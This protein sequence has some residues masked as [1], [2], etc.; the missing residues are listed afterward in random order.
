MFHEEDFFKEIS[1]LQEAKL[2]ILL[3]LVSPSIKSLI[4][5]GVQGTGKSHLAS[6]VGSVTNEPVIH[7]P[8]NATSDR[9]FGSVD[10]SGSLIQGKKILEYGLL[11]KADG[12]FLIIDDIQ[13]MDHSLITAILSTAETGHV[14]IEREGL[15][16]EYTTNFKVLATFNPAE[17][18][19]TPHLLDRFSLCAICE[20][21]S[22]PDERKRLLKN[23]IERKKAG[24]TGSNQS[25]S[26]YQKNHILKARDHYQYVS[27]PDGLKD[28]ITGLGKELGIIGHRGE[29]AHSYAARALTSLHEHDQVT[30]DD[31]SATAQ[32]ALQHRRTDIAREQN[33]SREDERIQS[34]QGD[35]PD[36][37]PEERGTPQTGVT[38]QAWNEDHP[39]ADSQALAQD[40]VFDIA[41]Y[42]SARDILHD[43]RTMV[44]LSSGKSGRRGSN[45]KKSDNG[46][47]HRSKIPSGQ[48]RDIA[49]DATIRQAAPY[50]QIRPRGNL[51]LHLTIQDIRVKERKRKTGRTI[52]FVVDSS[53]S[54]GVANRMSAVK[55]AILS[56]LQDAYVNR[57]QIAMIV[58]RGQSADLLLKPTRSGMTAY[59]ELAELPTGGQ[60]PLSLGIEK[61]I[62]IIKKIRLKHSNDV[63]LVI[64]LSDGRANYTNS[65]GDPLGEAW[66]AASAAKKLKARFIVIDAEYGYPRLYY[67]KKLA[68]SINGRYIRLEAMNEEKIVQLVR[69]ERAI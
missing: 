38:N 34:S 57:D 9:I 33:N 35:R 60:T 46:R 49:F 32:I 8:Q 51:A 54:M 18:E 47:Y 25:D 39:G 6:L 50:Q 56:L 27:I 55:G 20:G 24:D 45:N 3:L 13:N 67:A 53:G 41:D 11:Q 64:F 5:T 4:L 61:T 40:R 52:I 37:H 17:G 15:S 43:S 36:N 2:S 12:G 59:R 29:I 16:S 68:D 66:K 1:G 7:L 42:L 58:F 14:I 62:E 65:G 69:N 30:I 23:A 48:I 28:L 19:V 63:P 26:N 21:I 22:D 10:I 31:I 44:A